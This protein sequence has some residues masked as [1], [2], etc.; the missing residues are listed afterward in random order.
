MEKISELSA[1]KLPKGGKIVDLPL[2]DPNRWYR[3]PVA[4]AYWDLAPSTVWE[5]VRDGR[6][7]CIKNPYRIRGDV[8]AAGGECAGNGGG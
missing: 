8:I 5:R 3:V 7:P 4:A 1:M 2:L 6:V